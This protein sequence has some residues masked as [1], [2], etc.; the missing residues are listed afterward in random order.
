MFI[1]KA[2]LDSTIFAYDYHARLACIMTSQQIVLCELDPRHSY[3]TIVDAVS[4]N[5]EGVDG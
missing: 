5:C 1:G 2:V 4:E 3:D